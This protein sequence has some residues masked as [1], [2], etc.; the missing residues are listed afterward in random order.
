MLQALVFHNMFSELGFSLKKVLV[1]VESINEFVDIADCIS[2]PYS[3]HLYHTDHL[4][5]M[6]FSLCEGQEQFFLF[7][8]KIAYSVWSPVTIYRST[9]ALRISKCSSRSAPLLNLL[10]SAQ[11][12]KKKRVWEYRLDVMNSHVSISIIIVQTSCKCTTL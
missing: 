6:F 1:A 7:N 9:S 3:F 2:F 12:R 10:R 8:T 5:S 4:F 11:Q